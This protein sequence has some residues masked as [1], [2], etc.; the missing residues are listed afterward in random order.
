MEAAKQDK[1]GFDL[2]AATDQAIKACEGDTR[3][4][5]R[6][7]IVANNYLTVELEF[8]WQQ[9]SPGFSRGKRTRQASTGA[10]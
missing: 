8:A 6:A 2:E 1:P 5:I 9:V 7:L 4:A 3:A 10:D